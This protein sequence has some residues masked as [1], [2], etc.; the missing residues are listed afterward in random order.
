MRTKVVLPCAVLVRRWRFLVAGVSLPISLHR[1]SRKLPHCRLVSPRFGAVSRSR[2]IARMEVQPG[3]RSPSLKLCSKLLH[4]CGRCTDVESESAKTARFRAK[5][6]AT[7]YGRYRSRAALWSV[8][9]FPQGIEKIPRK[10]DALIKASVEADPLQPG[11]LLAHDRRTRLEAHTGLP[12]VFRSDPS[13]FRLEAAYAA[14]FALSQTSRHPLFGM[15]SIHRC[16]PKSVYRFLNSRSSL[17][18]PGPLVLS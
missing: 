9:R 6:T 3:G 4:N 5:S 14:R 2:P 8:I 12:V 17:L 10:R 13:A 16:H 11:E 7:L 18:P 1:Q 15:A